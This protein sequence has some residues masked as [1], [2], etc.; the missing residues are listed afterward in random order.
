[1]NTILSFGVMYTLY[2][3][4]TSVARNIQVAL[5]GLTGNTQQAADRVNAAL[6][7]M[8]KG[9]LALGAG[10]GVI[11]LLSASIKEAAAQEQTIIGFNTMIGSL[12]KSANFMNKLS[13]FA[14]KTPF[15]LQEVQELSKLLMATGFSLK[16]VLPTMKMLGDVAAG[17]GKDKLYRI[18]LAYSQIRGA[19]KLMGQELNQ[20]INANVPL[21]KAIGDL[22]GKTADQVKQMMVK[23]IAIPFSDVAKAFKN[24]TSEGGLFGNLME[25]QMTSFNGIMSQ[26]HDN[27]YRIKVNVGKALI[28]VLAP[29]SL[30]L[31][32][33]LELYS[34]FSST[35]I[36]AAAHQFLFLGGTILATYGATRIM[37]GGI[38]ILTM[39]M[40]VYR[41]ISVPALWSFGNAA[42]FARNSWTTYVAAVV[43]G[44]MEVIKGFFNMLANVSFNGI[45]AGMSTMYAAASPTLGVLLS[46]GAA[47]AVLSTAL[48]AMTGIGLKDFGLFGR[49]IAEMMNTF[50]EGGDFKFTEGLA[51]SLKKAGILN[52]VIELS[53]HI[54]ALWKFAKGFY[55]GLKNV[56]GLL[57]TTMKSVLGFVSWLITPLQRLT[58]GFDAFATLGKV[59][60]TIFGA[61]LL[62]YGVMSMVKAFR[63]LSMSTLKWVVGLLAVVVAF[64]GIK[65]AIEALKGIQQNKVQNRIGADKRDFMNQLSSGSLDF[66]RF[67]SSGLAEE[68]KNLLKSAILEYNNDINPAAITAA[69]ASR[70]LK[71]YPQARM[72]LSKGSTP[73][74]GNMTPDKQR[75]N[76]VVPIMM[77]SKR[78]SEVV[79]GVTEDKFEVINNLNIWGR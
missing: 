40:G 4:F 45:V 2:D 63:M 5:A 42:I 10:V 72:E 47:V 20:M 65:K 51:N 69:Q 12:A 50:T 22:S 16:E 18:V 24:M 33:F 1:M 26:L 28:S 54:F 34:A 70:L 23:G 59:L 39:A 41:A 8:K 77:D 76:I 79:I 44:R 36:G 25:K 64:Y 49:A 68:N 71:Q 53:G 57:Y 13:D 14:Y 29:L 19:S 61:G 27:V 66:R 60:G 48:S 67:T 3:G 15:D 55:T 21:L 75:A 6:S 56:F 30:L 62:L 32:N 9:M 37:Y 17:V 11:A 74:H 38:R 78:V 46:I 73:T 58:G 7:S 43:S 35:K 31:N 52:R